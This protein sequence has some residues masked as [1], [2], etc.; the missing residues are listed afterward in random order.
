M[1][2]NKQ[3]KRVKG[4]SRKTAFVFSGLGAQWNSMGVKLFEE[5]AVFRQKILECDRWFNTLANCSILEEMT[6]D[7]PQSPM[8][9]L[10]T[11]HR[12]IFSIQI[13]LVELLRH[14]GVSPDS[15]VGHSAGEVAAAHTAGVLSLEDAV[16]VIW[17]HCLL[18]DKAKGEGKMLFLAQS[19]TDV[20]DILEK[21]KKLSLAAINGP[22]S[23]VLSGSEGLEELSESLVKRGIFHRILNVDVPFHNSKIEPYLPQFQERLKDIRV[24]PARIPIYS[25]LHGTRVRTGDNCYN[26]LYWVKHI[27]ETVKF[28]PVIHEMVKDGHKVFIEISPHPV[29]SMAIEECL[30]DYKEKE[31]LVLGTLKRDAEEKKELLAV[32]SAMD[33]YG[34]TINRKKK[35]P[36]N[37]DKSSGKNKQKI[38]AAH[39]LQDASV[40]QEIKTYLVGKISSPLKASPTQINTNAN[41]IDLGLDSV[42]LIRLSK[43]IETDCRIK[44]YPTLFFEY[45]TIEAL[46]GY[47]IKTFPGEISQYFDL[48]YRQEAGESHPSER[49][50]P[51]GGRDTDDI[52][53][54]VE[55]V[56]ISR[57]AAN[58]KKDIAIIGIS[59]VFPGSPDVETFWRNLE[60]E[61]CL[62]SE[63][64]K[65]RWDWRTY[66]DDLDS[67]E[68][69]TSI[70]WGGFIDDIDKFNPLFFGISPREAAL[71]DPQQR[72]FLE[73]VW[74]AVE[75]AGYPASA[76]SA[77][78]TGLFVGVATNDYSDLMAEAHSDI[79]EYTYIGTAYSILANRISYLLNLHGPSE[80]VD[81]ACSGSL[82][83]IHRAVMSIQNGECDA[84][85]AGGVNALL[86]PKLYISFIKAGML[87]K[88][89]KCKAFDKSANG[90]VRGEGVGALILKPMQRALEDGD[91]IYGV[92]KSSAVNHG[93]HSNSLTA[94]NPNAQA[95]LLINAYEKGK[96]APDTISYI[97]AHGTGTALGDP[98]EINGLKK[99]F[100]VLYKRH[101]KSLPKQPHCGLGS[102]KTN[103]GHLEAAAGIA[104]VIK[105]LLSMKYKKLPASLHFQE[106][107]PFIQL[108]GSPF[109]IVNQTIPWETLKDDENRVV[110]RRA[111]ISSFGFGGANAHVVIE[112]A[113][114]IKSPSNGKP[115]FSCY[116]ICLSAKTGEA[117]RQKQQ[118]LALWLKKQAPQHNLS[119]ISAT[120][121]LGREHFGIRAAFVVK[122]ARELQQKLKEVIENG[123][124]RGYFKESN[125][126]NGKQLQHLSKEFGQTIIKEFHSGKKKSQREY[127]NKLM[128]LAELYAKGYDL[129]WRAIYADNQVHR[130]SLPTYP[131]AGERYWVPEVRG[132]RS[133]VGSQ[134]IHLLESQ[135]VT[136]A[137]SI[138]AN[139][140]GKPKPRGISLRSLSDRQIRLSKPVRQT[141]QS[142]T[143]SSTNIS[144]SLPQPGIN[145]ASKPT[146]HVQADIS[147]EFLQEELTASLAKVLYMKRSDVDIDKKFS[148][149]GLDS[150]LNVEWIQTINKK[151]GT[152]ITATKVYDYPT[153]RKFA[154]FLEKELKIH[155][156]GLGIKE[157]EN[158]STPISQIHEIE[159]VRGEYRSESSGG[160][161][162]IA[163][164]G[165]SGRYP[166]AS[167][168]NQYW[169][170]LVQAK[171]SIREIPGFRWDVNRYY[172]PVPMQKGKVYCKWLGLLEGI[173]YFDPLFFNILPAE[174]AL[175]DPQHR[176][177][178]QEG[179]KAFE[180]AG[181][182]CQLLS[183]K[184]C[185]VYLGIMSNEYGL[186][187]AQNQL[188][189]TD[190][191]GNSFAIAAARLPYYLNL[192]GPAIPIDTACS[193]SLTA[194]HL[195]C[196]ALLNHEI[197]M[198]L[199]GG[200]SLYLT[201]GPYIG[202]CAAEMLS[203]RGQCKPFDDSADGFVPGEGAGAL[204]LKRL[205]AAQADGD[206]IYGVIIG[207]G[208]NHDGKTNG[209]S[210]PS[211]NSQIQLERDI[212][213]K[214]QIDPRSIGYIETHGTGTKLG[215]LIEL[216]ALSTVFKEKTD[217]KNYC[218]L[219][220][221]KGNI[222]HTS[223][224]AGVASIQKVLLGMKHK[225]LV[226]TLNFKKPN[227]HFDFEDSPFYVNTRLCTWEAP[228]GTPRR[229][230]VSSFG[231][232]GTNVHIVIEEP[233]GEN[234]NAPVQKKDGGR[235]TNYKQKTSFSLPGAKNRERNA[236]NMIIFLLSAKSEPQ[237]KTYAERMKR[238][239][240]CDEDLDLV[241]MAYTL[242][243]GREPMDHRL[244]VLAD[245]REALI[246]ALE[247]FINNNPPAEVL[248]AR[249]KRNEE[250]KEEFAA[251]EE[252]ETLLQNLIGEKKLKQAAALWVKGSNA[253]WRP[254]YGDGK[255]PP[256]RRIS[257]PTYPFA[258]ERCW[259]PGT[260][261]LAGSTAANPV[262]APETYIYDEPFLKD[263]TIYNRRVL[264][265]LTH[266]SLAL[267][268]FF[269]LFPEE[270]CVH[271]HRLDFV[272]PIAVDRDRAVEVLVKTVQK[273]SGLDF[274]VV[275]R[276]VSAAAWDIT[277][278]G[279][280][281][282]TLFESKKIDIER[283]KDSLE[284]N[285]HFNQIYTW[286]PAI[287]LGDSFKTITH[288][289]TG[290]DRVL[291]R[292]ALKQT[293]RKENHDYVL[294]P[295][296]INSAFLAV[297]PLLEPLN[298]KNGFLP[299]GI[300]D[301]HF[302]KT[303]RLEH[304][305]LLVRLVK[306]SGEIII[307]DADVITD[308]SGVVA[309]YSGCSLKRLRSAGQFPAK[310][311]LIPDSTGQR[312][313]NQVTS[314][315]HHL[316][317]PAKPT[318][319]SGKIQKYLMN[320]L[321][322]IVP[323]RST[324]SHLE[325][326]LMDMG[327][328][329]SQLVKL[330]NEIA[331][332]TGIELFPTLFFEY[333]NIKE[334]AE[335]FS[336]EHQDSF[337]GLW[338]SPA[339]QSGGP[340]AGHQTMES[341][342]PPPARASAATGTD[343]DDIAVIG[344]SGMFAEASDLDRFWN[345]L[346]D[347]K[348]VIKEIPVDHWDYHPW[349]DR[350]PEAK[351]KTYCKWGS[352]IE[353]V[354]HFD[355]EF[356]NISPREAEW[357]DPQLRL[358]L[359][360][361]YAAGED[362]GYINQLR[363]TDTG[364][365][366]GVCC[367]DYT[368]R[369]AEMNL[370][371][372]PYSRTGNSQAVIANRVSFFFD[373]T[374]PSI[375]VDTTCSSSLFALHQACQALR[376]KE[377]DMA[378][379]G[380][381]NLVLSSAHYRY[382]CS[383]GALSPTGRC[384]TFDEAADGYVP[385]ECIGS[386]LLKP[387]SRA[388]KDGDHIYAIIKGSAALHGG[389]TSSFTAPAVAGE[390]NVIVKA[391][392]NAGINPETLTYIE[393]H[394]TGTK[395]GDPIEITSLKKAFKRFTDKE[396]FCA[397]GSVKAN[398][399]HTE[400]AAG[401]AGILRVILQMKHRQI[402]AMPQFKKP[403]PY[404]QL[405]KS[406]FYIN[407]ELEEW[408][409]PAGV[410]RRAGVSSFG[411][412]GAYAH[413][414]IEEY[415]PGASNMR[416][417][418]DGRQEEQQ[419]TVST[420]KP[421][422]ILLSAKNKERLREQAQRLLAAIRERQFSDTHLADIAYTLQVGRE[423]MEERLAVMVWSIKELREKLEGFLEG[424]DVEDLYRG[425]VNGDKGTLAVF[426]ADEDL[427]KTIDTW[428]TKRRYAKLLDFWA[429]GLTVDWTKLYGNTK[430]HKPRRISLPT[431]P[432]AGER[433]WVPEVRGEKWEVGVQ[434]IHPLLQQNTANLS[435]QR[436]S[437][438]FTGQ[439]FF[440]ADHIV[441]GQRVLPGVA[442]LEM[443]RAAV[444][445]AV[446]GMEED[447]AVIRLKN[448]V[449]TRP[450]VVGDEP[451]RVHI[452]LYPEDNGQ[453]AFE[454]YSKSREDDAESVVHSQGRAVLS[455]T[456]EA[457]I[458]DLPA[459]KTRCSQISLSSGQCYQAF[460]ETGLHHG[461]AYRGVEVI[462]VEPGGGQAL[463]KLSLPSTVSDTLDRFVLHPGLMDSA[464]HVITGLV[465]DTAQPMQPGDAASPNPRIP[466]VL[467]EID[468]LGSCTSQMWSL[469]R[470]SN[471]GKAGDSVQKFDIDLCDETGMVC[472][473][474]KG[475]SLRVL[476]NTVG[477]AN[478][479]SP[480]VNGSAEDKKI[481][482]LM[483]HPSWKERPVANEAEAPAPGC[484]QHLV[485]L[486]EPKERWKMGNE[487]AGFIIIQLQSKQK[488][489]EKR[490]QTYAARVFEEIQ[491]IIKE[492][493]KDRVL[494]QVVVPA[495]DE[496]QLFSGLSGLLK[497]AH[498]ENPKLIGQ[499]IAVDPGEDWQG[500]LE[501]LMDNSR[502]PLDDQVLY[503]DGKRYVP[504][505]SD[506]I[507]PISPIG[508]MALPWKDRGIYLITGG[509]G[510][511]GL[512]FAKEIIRQVKNAT[513]ILTGRSPLGE[514]RQ[515][516]IKELGA[517]GAR[518]EYKQVD[519]TQKK[520][521]ANLI[522]GIR[523][524]FG[525]LHG[526]I[527]SAGVTR[528]NYI[529]KKSREEMQEVLA[530][531]VTGVV[532][533]DQASKDLSLD[534]F[535]FFSST[536][537]ALGNPGQAGYST[538][539]A[540][541][542][543]Y[544]RY[545]N[546]LAAAKKRQG[547]TL[548]INWPL[549]K[550]GGM[551][552]DEET[553]KM[554]GQNLGMISMQTTTG[555]RAFYQALATGKHQV[556]VIE[557]KVA[558]IK[559]KL[560]STSMTSPTTPKPGK[561]PLAAYAAE[562]DIG[563]LRDKVQAM[564]IQ[565]VSKL[566]GIKIENIDTGA[567][568]SKYGFDSLTLTE[569]SNKLNREYKLELTP[570]LFFQH[571]TLRSLAGYL[572]EEHR[573]AFAA[574]FAGQAR[575]GAPG[576]AAAGQREE[577][578]I[579]RKQR[580]RFARTAAL[581]A[582]KPGTFVPKVP[583][584]IAI[585]G[586]SGRFP[587]AADVD[588]FWRN[589]AEGKDC[590]TEIPED[591][592]DWR[593]Y[594]GDPTKEANK[595]NVKWGG[596]IDGVD[597]FD[598]LFFGISPKEAKLMDPQ[599]RL[600]MVY[601]WK[602]IED[603]G[604]SAQSLSGTQ[605]GIFVGTAESGYGSLISRA[606]LAIEGYASTGMVPSVGPNRMSYFLN[607][608]GPSE[609][610]ETACSSS[611]VALHR[612][613]EAIGS[614]TCDM[615]IVG[616][617]NTIVTPEL[618]ISFNKAGMLCEDGRCK[619]FSNK[620]NGYVRG[621]GVGMLF[622]KKL[623]DAEQAGDH[624]YGVIR[625]TAENHGGRAN[626]LTAPNPKAQAELLKT[627]YT[628]A[629]IDPRT[630][631]Y[632]E[633][634]GTGTDLGDPIEI[635]GLKT[636]FKELYQVTGDGD[637]LVGNAHCGLGS[638]KS[639]IGH[640]ELAAG[641]AGVIKVLLQFKYK[642]LAKS[643]H[644]DT[645][646][647]HIQLE[648]SPFYINRETK[649]WRA[650][651][652]ARGQDLPRRAGVSS[653]GF[654]GTNAH[655]VLEEWPG[656]SGSTDRGQAPVQPH[657]I[658][659]SARNE[660]RLNAYAKDIV[661]YLKKVE[662]GEDES[663]SKISLKD[664]AYTLQV[665]RDAMEERLALM[666]WSIKELREKL[667]AVSEGRDGDKYLYRGHVK[668]NKE[669]LAVLAA[670]EDM[671]K[672]I[673]AWIAKGKFAKLLNLWVKG[674]IFDWNKLYEG[675]SPKPRRISLPT[676]PFARERCWIPGINVQTAGSTAS[677]AAAGSIIPKIIDKP[678]GIS[679]RSLSGDQPPASKPAGQTQKV[680]T[681]SPGHI[682]L[683]P[684]GSSDESKAV[685]QAKAAISV[686]SLQE[687]LRASLVEALYMK[688]SDVDVD[689][690]F[691]DM[692]LDSIT[693]VEWVQAINKQ[694]GTSI[695]ATKVYD[696]PSIGEFAGFLEKELNKQGGGLM[697]TPLKSTPSL[698]L[699]DL[700]QKVHQGVLDIEQADRLFR[701]FHC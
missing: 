634:H 552:V 184:K 675:S 131:F 379:V 503:Q 647:P 445:Q 458:L 655:V 31:Y 249:V 199:V 406:P 236:D 245:S 321:A 530:P 144:L 257:L 279:N 408:K 540:F 465:K 575:A 24:R 154:G 332:E 326:N 627:A 222:G 153:L 441:K 87:S 507:G 396:Q 68:N 119:D 668:R 78:N 252:A 498:L 26:G 77:T 36:Q 104:G 630:V 629:G 569:F 562:L 93:G 527:H 137:A 407:R 79:V 162:C 435:E 460:R 5:E 250:V 320:K 692:G 186:M 346:R 650:Q 410:P 209:I 447:R 605:T 496:Q 493:P 652:D 677:P 261:T 139:I 341:I 392:E 143:S 22:K 165:M 436:F 345:N 554:M 270:Y 568:L 40:V 367:H 366:V 323:D 304:C 484:V 539:N 271:L 141:Q 673:A 25:S 551:Q 617:I 308:E 39:Q 461:P 579:N 378:F 610:I 485:I 96:I 9:K 173:E 302:K 300:K 525:G 505:W 294:H 488:S 201:P 620:A 125:P 566:L 491:R 510:G 116:L 640:L 580:S 543:A 240:E 642:T 187:L 440:L 284:E 327:L 558:R 514:D 322:K 233:H 662:A 398:I 606:N 516:R 573:A 648:D 268:A 166:G 248:T 179:Y 100:E 174:A 452:G 405:E 700:V 206:S 91:H 142:I 212:Y 681:L 365:F 594:Y 370:P 686:E 164:V 672:T 546:A 193:S 455:S 146:T 259:I 348:D 224:A 155:G 581:S 158:P 169:D 618:H 438:T 499:L 437:S 325:F 584:P 347:K 393:A 239:I 138:P 151:Y 283:I 663:L 424:Q 108:Q 409:S 84:A 637:S 532:N 478:L 646:N 434:V 368:D 603:A 387:F 624:I 538:A 474:M 76:L 589:L 238:F 32:L 97:E 653:F 85:I 337:T 225:K 403:N 391:W 421:A 511:L 234:Y 389:Y 213:D 258:R 626:S 360:N 565:S 388:Q 352:F 70:R 90:Y 42:A 219:G 364:V 674:L 623:D 588:E 170:N 523:E 316:E 497:T 130:I 382:F 188:G 168:L 541:M 556:M 544:A 122:N 211:R 264:I 351:D 198:A 362:A 576:Q 698:S 229:A 118:D 616:G 95:N 597:E 487:E 374:G 15:L 72:I 99:T 670:D 394:G 136:V 16:Q 601:V 253:D 303:N 242:Q 451:V 218:A 181:Y 110:P 291:A 517:L 416:E 200:V 295:I 537:G 430:P 64:P 67:P 1:K 515:A 51:D 422:I 147:A 400:G 145:D 171:N 126:G 386:I 71:M 481:S 427:A 276:E 696:Y 191:T 411:L 608:H 641:I 223:A 664:I 395:L 615:A 683:S 611:L 361:I 355:A 73:T 614:G 241:D 246:N 177:F 349:Y 534:F 482:T 182:N 631:S 596:F 231:F 159:S 287:G 659:L 88:D 402:P 175:M 425:H 247:G 358:L 471:G 684:T 390:E 260:D 417:E 553:E 550:E 293:S 314:H 297:A 66:V 644:C 536:A 446:V 103:I 578:P 61:R 274:Q 669:I 571:P 254:L 604:Y 333:P 214:Y 207:S 667:E 299:F 267:N 371:I 479:K 383:I 376:H 671:E 3:G 380:G 190:T 404:L 572:L 46:A 489:I 280:L 595:T 197:D 319:L 509:A 342:P 560:L 273:G 353:H 444:E 133:E 561:V 33:S 635:N 92:I 27:R 429:R 359:Q 115:P 185:G 473:R 466:F 56:P 156:G 59:G 372:N 160:K 613:V 263:H 619:T 189:L 622:L 7:A 519:V 701:Q 244:A 651:Q 439:E 418:V 289:Y 109:Y 563:G 687:E 301:I 49:Q 401:I 591:R 494:V 656:V 477:I 593:E 63:I 469:V 636:A 105:V 654:G 20:Q 149:I 419:N 310:D 483:L 524:D 194:T 585:V 420:G 457:P 336:R 54:R 397:I 161:E 65:D 454:I 468:I 548:S 363:G 399:G 600:L 98:V 694:Y 129:D 60:E 277:A 506:N 633:T 55:S 691:I 480:L 628:R 111:G 23:V 243:V 150:I 689:K 262:L 288:L 29:L 317:T 453:I 645:I 45:Q 140:P 528:D 607:F 89:G 157:V 114:V 690:K 470:Y 533:L 682:S 680:I 625:A 643:L 449:W 57:S 598:S 369:I 217:R 215:D 107:N 281:Q 74:K 148:D 220:S 343:R 35:E 685:T 531:K 567:E 375:A 230:G 81:T 232:S 513:L 28:E 62:V 282:K 587:M 504:G 344:M 472:V 50:P 47:L 658:I 256:P 385:G 312:Q 106:P 557:G 666:V 443:T 210:A 377:C 94:P 307:F 415:I 545:R 21:N 30:K 501:K 127:S 464:L 8:E 152:S 547:K 592:W 14:W 309:H 495:R 448:V 602:A 296:I 621:E 665:G 255:S 176:L 609:P 52:V 357:M 313:Q 123:E 475:F 442:C 117:L 53:K 431:Y 428:I 102:V 459:L 335:F 492:K 69:K 6:S 559:E 350:N 328:K 292:V 456:A 340:E 329:S 265:G 486:C 48:P 235:M 500:I 278:T 298:K 639:N 334:L 570:T 324:L 37:K 549:W 43:D 661:N 649:E 120:L 697:Q 678:V 688:Q 305:W 17:Q 226:P 521:V 502:S 373:F 318:H 522:Q 526:I 286:N 693:G 384:H 269:K 80:S 574:G 381:V 180:D 306:N 75:D 657:L 101:G 128:A 612:A 167:H 216:E 19:I 467:E 679:L 34:H 356:F 586:M 251:N 529:F 228:P 520:A 535:V 660:S 172:D 331:K 183:N 518:I 86:S 508:P 124:T 512:I 202:M 577:N 203:P 413:V 18:F 450:I 330:T 490:F 590:I 412:T 13:A 112:E 178:L 285:H 10:S 132:R 272:K 583:G 275:Y 542:D 632:I 12:C 237:L 599:Q 676:Y 38:E 695:P 426:A 221:V 339:A 11:A 208:I 354:G 582:A 195:A 315:P 564:L 290:K 2:K 196:Q 476:E 58:G 204:V 338:G 432:F 41:L 134:V 463:G 555:I 227:E 135:P 163:I 82:V 192:K 433:Y 266:A 4:Q 462:Y 113:P 44:L 414:V 423:A 638:V 205:T 699:S 83:A 311:H 121:L